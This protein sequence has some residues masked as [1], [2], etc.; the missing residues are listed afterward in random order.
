MI[1][2][3]D[4]EA[5]LNVAEARPLSID[6][7]SEIRHLHRLSFH[8]LADRRHA[9]D[10][11]EA[12]DAWLHDPA[13]TASVMESDLTGLWVDR[14]LIGTAGWQPGEG[15]EPTA[16]IVHVSVNPLF[17]GLGLGHHLVAYTE[18]RARR[19][20]FLRF[21][22]RATANAV[23]FFETLGYEVTSHG[24]TPLSQ[25]AGLPVTFMRRR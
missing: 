21:S 22:A 8:R 3:S 18:E 20:G 19:A 23:H 2:N 12:F 7:L 24:M 11:A 9:A 10:L 14:S 5:I 25:G 1:C 6:D 13:Y 16:R 17:C 15:S 4:A